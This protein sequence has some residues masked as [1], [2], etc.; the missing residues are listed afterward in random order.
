[1]PLKALVNYRSSRGFFGLSSEAEVGAAYAQ[2]AALVSFL[3]QPQY[4]EGFFNY[5]RVVRARTNLRQLVQV[6]RLELLCRYL[7]LDSQELERRFQEF[8]RQNA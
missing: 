1:M 8:L 2:S 3:M 7:N 4:R 6:C 5:I